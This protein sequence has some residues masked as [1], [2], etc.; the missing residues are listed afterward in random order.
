MLISGGHLKHWRR[1]LIKTGLDLKLC[2]N[3]NYDTPQILLF[4]EMRAI[5]H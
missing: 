3:Y 5:L 1:T 4:L 2:F